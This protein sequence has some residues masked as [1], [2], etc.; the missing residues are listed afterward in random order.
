ML[1]DL[2]PKVEKIDPYWS[3]KTKMKS[4]K[5]EKEVRELEILLDD[6][7]L[8]LDEKRKRL[9]VDESK[10]IKPFVEPPKPRPNW[11]AIQKEREERE[12]Q[13]QEEMEHRENV[14]KADQVLTNLRINKIENVTA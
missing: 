12:R 11:V 5:R 3:V 13:L 14:I 4:V 2:N 8:P 10:I 6:I 7:A 9:I 1:G